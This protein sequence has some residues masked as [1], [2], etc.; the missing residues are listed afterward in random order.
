MEV[1]LLLHMWESTTC[2]DGN[3]YLVR[4]LLGSSTWIRPA[5]WYSP[6]AIIS[7]QQT[8][9]CWRWRTKI[10]SRYFNQTKGNSIERLLPALGPMS[11]TSLLSRCINFCFRWEPV[12]HV[13]KRLGKASF[14]DKIIL[15]SLQM[16]TNNFPTFR[17]W[18]LYCT[19]IPQHHYWMPVKASSFCTMTP[20]RSFSQ[21][22]AR[23]PLNLAQA[24]IASQSTSRNLPRNSDMYVPCR[25]DGGRPWS[26]LVFWFSP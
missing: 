1:R 10:A 22:P 13:W 8:K 17:S 19:E 6:P 23:S 15:A 25:F 16:W 24:C 12:M 11:N 2:N 21:E 4:K 9:Q 18:G 3:H 7:G 14:L 26:C 20:H 5:D